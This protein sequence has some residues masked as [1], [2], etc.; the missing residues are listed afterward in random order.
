IKSGETVVRIE[1]TNPL[2]ANCPH[3]LTTIP[4]IFISLGN[5]YHLQDIPRVRTFI[6][7]YANNQEVMDAVMEKL[8]GRSEFT[9]IS[10]VDPFCGKWDTRL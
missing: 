10:P 9:G 2:G 7:A 3:F 8:T 6:N 5:P 1:W 4:T